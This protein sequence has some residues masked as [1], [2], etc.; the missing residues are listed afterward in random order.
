M[1]IFTISFLLLLVGAGSSAARVFT[2][3]DGRTMEAQFI[4]ATDT[5]VVVMILKSGRIHRLK[6][7]ILSDK[8]ARY[9]ATKRASMSEAEKEEAAEAARLA[10]MKEGARK[11]V[12]FV[13]KN[14][15]EK[16]G[17]GE[18]W[19][20]ANEAFKSAGIK[21]PGKDWRIWGGVVNWREEDV[22]PGDILELRSAKF[23][24]GQHSGPKHTAVVVKKSRRRG[25]V[26]VAHQNWGI[27]GKKVSVLMLHLD[28]LEEGEATIYRYGRR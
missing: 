26:M 16:V 5:E 24:N 4:E 19:T 18:C 13:L 20:L 22:L 27:P 2:D 15:G 12:E 25:E 6:I 1:R 7:A 17:D 28:Q 8:D 23:S 9:V 21:R 10:A 11:V 3:R 14:R